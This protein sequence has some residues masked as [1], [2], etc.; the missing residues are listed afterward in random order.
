MPTTTNYG[1][2]TPADTDLVKDGAAAIRTLG[3]S[4]D[5]SVKSLN[6]G[7][8]AGD[9]DYY[10]S[11]TAK[12]RI[13]IGTNGQV[14]TSNGTVP[15]WGAAPSGSLTL[16]TIASGTLSGTALNL[17]GLTQDFLQL[18]LAAPTWASSSSYLT[19]RIN[20]N[21]SGTY[22]QLAVQQIGNTTYGRDYNNSTGN[23]QFLPTGNQSQLFSNADGFY[24]MNFYN[25]KNSGFTAYQAI[26][27]CANPSNQSM[28]SHNW[29]V[30]KTAAAVTQL[31]IALN[32]GQSFN[33]GTYSLI[34]G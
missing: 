21:S 32:G 6:A 8:T 25:C 29:G 12:A 15:T 4:I 17:T 28:I 24:V 20:N 19:V 2:T 26:S 14:L 11:S 3:S 34:G 9:L 13:G 7:T 18:R 23:S 33:G 22:D 30:F 10:T 27:Y 1:W 16:S 31:N 5:T